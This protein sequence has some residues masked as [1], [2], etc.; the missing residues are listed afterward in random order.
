M[1]EF[2]R[3]LGLDAKMDRFGLKSEIGPCLDETAKGA[4][5]SVHD[6]VYSEMDAVE[7][8]RCHDGSGHLLSP[9]FVYR[10]GTAMM[11]DLSD[12]ASGLWFERK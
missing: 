1:A 3:G 6:T 10:E 9:W 7:T 11:K 12:C 5:V 8:V 2:Q 4:A